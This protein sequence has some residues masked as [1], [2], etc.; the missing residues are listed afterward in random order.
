MISHCNGRWQ[1]RAKV[2]CLR[3]AGD[4]QQGTGS[5]T[6]LESS[7]PSF[8]TALQEQLGLKLE[9]QKLGK[10]SSSIMLKSLRRINSGQEQR[11]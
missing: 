10:F 11:C 3:G 1:T 4:D 5:A 6:P 2:P 9:S 7:G 8:F